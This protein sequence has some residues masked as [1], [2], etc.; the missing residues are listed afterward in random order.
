MI[1]ERSTLED[2]AFEVCTAL[3][4]IGITAV[5]TGGSAATYYA[6]E[7][8]QSDDVDFV[9]TM[10]MTLPGGEQ[11]LVRLGYRRDGDFYVHERTRFPLEFPPGPLMVGAEHIQ[12]WHTER[13][14][15]RLLHVLTPTDSCRDRLAAFMFWNDF[16]SL[17]QAIAV[18]RS[19]RR[20]MDLDLV[21]TWCTQEGHAD[22]YRVFETRL[23]KLKLVD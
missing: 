21:R 5:L 12:N 7:A 23:R 18:A 16:S 19:R 11:A 9:I 8:I 4:E 1:T 6:P 3:D 15:K 20:D 22:K 2:V 14:K 10:G 13:R 17:D